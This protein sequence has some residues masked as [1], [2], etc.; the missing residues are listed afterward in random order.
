MSRAEVASSHHH[1][2]GGE[3]QSFAQPLNAGASG[4]LPTFTATREVNPETGGRFFT[5]SLEADGAM[6]LTTTNK[7]TMAYIGRCLIELA[8]EKG[9]FAHGVR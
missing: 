5:V 8:E 6:A 2:E 3:F 1:Y 7:E 9:R 4:Q